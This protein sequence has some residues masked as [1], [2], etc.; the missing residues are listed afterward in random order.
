MLT[1]PYGTGNTI[2]ATDAQI[3]N[4]SKLNGVYAYTAGDE[5]N[6]PGAT[7]EEY[8]QFDGLTMIEMTM[9]VLVDTVNPN[10]GLYGGYNAD[11][12]F[13]GTEKLGFANTNGF[14]KVISIFNSTGTAYPQAARAASSIIANL[15]NPDLPSTGNACD[16]YNLWSA[17]GSLKS[18][19]A[20]ASTVYAGI[21]DGNLVLCEEGDEGAQA[22]TVVDFIN[23]SHEL[24]GADAVRITFDKIKG[25]K[26]SDGA[27][28]HSYTS[29][30]TMHQG[31]PIAPS[32][33]NLGDVDATCIASTGLVRSMFTAFGMG[34][35]RPSFF[36][37]ADY[38]R[39]I[40]YIEAA[41][42]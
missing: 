2:N 3:K 26:K 20:S 39:F 32:G 35:Y 7:A 11:G 30:G 18:N 31:C 36:G 4:Y 33:N 17:I 16:V 23:S 34:S 13:S 10:T 6:T 12:S 1:S 14:F 38:M 5:A 42:L 15:T 28:S 25:Y 8:R 27:F 24:R 21:A 22:M 40:D 29:G 9:K 41:D 19:T 37:K